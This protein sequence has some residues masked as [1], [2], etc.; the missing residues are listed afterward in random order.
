MNIYSQ[1]QSRIK[2]YGAECRIVP[3]TYLKELE[4][5][6]FRPFNNSLIDKQLSE[7]YIQGNIDFS[8]KGK[9]PTVQ[10]LIIIATPSPSVEVHF[11][12]KHNDYALTIPPIY[13]DRFIVLERIKEITSQIF[14]THGYQTFPVVL[15]K[16]LI[17][18]HSG[19]AEYGKNNLVYVNGMGSFHRLTLFATDLPCTQDLWQNLQQLDSCKTCSA[20]QRHCPTAAIQNENFIIKAER[21]LTYLNEQPGK[22]PGWVDPV[23]HNSIIGCL[24]CQEIC[25]ENKNYITPLKHK[26]KFNENET[27][28]IINNTPFEK[29]PQPLKNKIHQLCLHCYYTLLSR[30]I[31]SLLHTQ[32]R[33]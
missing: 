17:A 18:V 29:L 2:E 10:S 31:S 30:N 7:K 3:I 22:F 6:Y 23:W 8:I 32:M 20:C 4:S 15:P 14:D 19:L 5:E 27:T 9:Y 21:C 13:T 25:P 24:K 11:Q 16:K 1:F 28:M 12:Y 33:F 26:I